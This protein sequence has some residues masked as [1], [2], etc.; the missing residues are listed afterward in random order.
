MKSKAT[1]L[2]LA[3]ATLGC[4]SILISGAMANS[5]ETSVTPSANQQTH[6]IAKP[7]PIPEMTT[8]DLL[9]LLISEG[10]ISKEA[11]IRL[12]T[13]LR[14]RA[15]QEQNAKNP[16]ESI[17]LNSDSTST[18]VVPY[19]PPHIEQKIVDSVKDS[20][21][22]DVIKEAK[23]EGIRAPSWTEK[24]TLS[25][26]VRVR[27]SAEFYPDDNPRYGVFN[28][29]EVNDAGSTVD[30][31][32]D[33]YVNISDDRHRLQGR[34][35]LMVKAKPNDNTEIGIRL[36]SGNAGNPVSANQTLGKYGKKWETSFDLAYVQYQNDRLLLSAGRMKN[37][38]L[39]TD[40]VWDNDMTFE[41]LFAQVVPFKLGND[42]RHWD[43][44]FN[45]GAFPLQEIHQFEFEDDVFDAPDDKWIYNF[46]LGSEIHFNQNH[47]IDFA[48]N[49]YEF[50][51][52]KGFK[53]APGGDSQNI[54]AP[55]FMQWYNLTHNMAVSLP[56]DSQEELYGL[57]SEF[58]VVNFTLLYDYFGLD[59]Y[60]LSVGGH[61][62]QN[63]AW[64]AGEAYALAA[65]NEEGPFPDR[66]TGYQ[67]EMGFATKQQGKRGDWGVSLAYRYLEGDAVMDAFADSDFLIGGTNAQGY[68]LKGHQY[69][70][71]NVSL[72]LRFISADEVD[73]PIAKVGENGEIVGDIREDAV[74]LDLYA[75]F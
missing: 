74:L 61:Y 71:E 62:V 19:I 28:Y 16:D 55:P 59:K 22:E 63:I 50:K 64:D 6:S 68:I 27:Y 35:R 32:R 8:T 1:N 60:K 44:Y 56:G 9:N 52:V 54:A 51:N 41:G 46:G 75:R 4:T 58:E 31:G 33:A 30:A 13:T 18:I 12:L 40:L 42:K 24:V 67:L 65:P 2:K 73:F 34:A 17:P 48:L 37:P 29:N 7:T 10:A 43:T 26:D 39:T 23:E 38:W 49:Y 36:T 47:D 21:T 11:A 45:L 72:E 25:G 66:D 57:A 69:M 70:T 3:F 5:E 20:I 53:N 14:Q 15:N